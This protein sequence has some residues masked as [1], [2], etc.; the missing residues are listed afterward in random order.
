MWCLGFESPLDSKAIPK[1]HHRIVRIPPGECV[2]LNS[3]ERAPFLL[4]I[5]ILHDDLDFDSGKLNNRELIREMIRKDLRSKKYADDEL[6][7]RYVVDEAAGNLPSSV[8]DQTASDALY[9]VENK[10][11]SDLLS[12]GITQPPTIQNT[13]IQEEEVDLVEQIYGENFSVHQTPD[14]S[15]TLVVPVQPK[16]RALDI[17]TWSRASSLPPSPALTPSVSVGISTPASIQKTNSFQSPSNVYETAHGTTE[18]GT[19]RIPVSSLD[20][21]SERMR[22]AA[23]MLAQ[24]NAS[25]HETATP[26]H[27]D[28]LANRTRTSAD[29]SGA[30]GTSGPLHPSLSGNLQDPSKYVTPGPSGSTRMKLQTTEVAAI[31]ERIMQEMIA[32]EEERMARMQASQDSGNI[33]SFETGQGNL[34]TTEDEQIIRRELNRIDPSAIVFQESWA[35][36]KVSIY[37]LM[38]SPVLNASFVRVGYGKTL[39][40]AILHLGIAFPSS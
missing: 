22:T 33:I 15:E 6:N 14:L 8:L 18:S 34:K 21:Y 26:S 39:L 38:P 19:S 31:R 27:T 11:S 10:L 30:T 29:D 23:I 32:L 4:L 3:A 24:L 7:Q 40:M 17:A 9:P 35:A 28:T 5:E 36:K 12:Q 16:N 13:T 20:E 37:S 2:V 1:P 25:L